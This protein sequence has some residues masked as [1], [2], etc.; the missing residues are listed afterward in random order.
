MLEN[1]GWNSE[2]SPIRLEGTLID[3][4]DM[5]RV[6]LKAI[7]YN[8]N[9]PPVGLCFTEDEMDELISVLCPGRHYFHE[10][11]FRSLLLATGGHVGAL[12]DFMRIIVV[13]SASDLDDQSNF[14]FQC[15]PGTRY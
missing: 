14:T 1:E 8:D 13:C 7:P 3:L 9:L 4:N 11:F 10:R 12:C 6:T 15:I 5:Q 2:D